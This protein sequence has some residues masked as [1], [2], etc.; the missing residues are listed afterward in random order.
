MHLES[1]EKQ[2]CLQ[3]RLIV[4]ISTMPENE[5]SSAAPMKIGLESTEKLDFL[6]S[7][8]YSIGLIVLILT[9]PEK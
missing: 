4:L 7:F 2:F 8:Y 5:P 6:F 9:V 1:T 3:H